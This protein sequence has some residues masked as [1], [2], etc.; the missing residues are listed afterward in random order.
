MAKSEVQEITIK[1]NADTSEVDAAIEK[2]K[3]AQEE[4]LSDQEIW[5]RAF[6]SICTLHG[7]PNSAKGHSYCS[8]AADQ[9]L[10]KVKAL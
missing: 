4:K 2:I 10:K 1:I 8:D 9:V 6:H 3:K 5:L 7:T